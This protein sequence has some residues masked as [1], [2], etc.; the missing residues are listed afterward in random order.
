MLQ[1]MFIGQ[2]T[3]HNFIHLNDTIGLFP[4]L[5]NI[6][7]IGNDNDRKQRVVLLPNLLKDLLRD[8]PNLYNLHKI[9]I[10]Q[11]REKKLAIHNTLETYKQKFRAIGWNIRLKQQMERR[12]TMPYTLCKNILIL[13]KKKQKSYTV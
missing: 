4:N 5:Q 13:N 3:N 10:I 12:Q 11:P 7:I 8:L 1:S 2:E 9:T 6:Q